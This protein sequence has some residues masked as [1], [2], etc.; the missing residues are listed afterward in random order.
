M[1]YGTKTIEY[2]SQVLSIGR[3]ILCS[4]VSIRVIQELPIYTPLNIEGVVYLQLSHNC[5][6]EIKPELLRSLGLVHRVTYSDKNA[7][8]H[9]VTEITKGFSSLLKLPRISCLPLWVARYL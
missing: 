1:V 8:L 4:L 9:Q 5:R 2:G 6:P 3:D 7:C